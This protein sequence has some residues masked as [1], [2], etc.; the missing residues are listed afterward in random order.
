MSQP[1]PPKLPPPATPTNS[2]RYDSALRTTA[3]IALVACPTL[4]LLPPRKLDFYTVGLI[5]ATGYSANFLIR[6]RIGRSIWQNIAPQR[7]RVEPLAHQHA[8]VPPTE[9]ANLHKELNH[10]KDELQRMGKEG[11]AGAVTEEILGRREAWKIQRER[12]VKEELEE[13]KGL[14][15]M[16]TDQIWEVWNWGKGKED[17]DEEEG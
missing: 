15:D 11:Q 7:R 6:E 5:T 4:A 12:E 9:Q 8:G 17:E 13:G 1:H 3:Y 16:I 14:S 2:D 10:A